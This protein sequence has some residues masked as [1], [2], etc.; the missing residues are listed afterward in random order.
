[1]GPSRTCGVCVSALGVPSTR[2]LL[3]AIGCPAD[4]TECQVV[5]GSGGGGGGGVVAGRWIGLSSLEPSH[6]PPPSCL[7][8]DET[9]AVLASVTDTF[10][11]T[12]GGDREWVCCCMLLLLLLLL[13]L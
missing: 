6:V 13:S 10:G 7:A 3:L 1:M 8:I 12:T 4:S 2:R 9:F 5:F 11:L